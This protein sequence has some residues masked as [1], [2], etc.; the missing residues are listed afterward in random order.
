MLGSTRCYALELVR[1]L[2]VRPAA[3]AVARPIGAGSVCAT[4]A[5]IG[6]HH[7]PR[8]RDA[9]AASR[10]A[11]PT[12]NTVFLPRA[13]VCSANRRRENGLGRR[14]ALSCAPKCAD[15]AQA[16][17]KARNFAV[18]SA[19]DRKMNTELKNTLPASARTF[20]A[21]YAVAAR[22]TCGTIFRHGDSVSF[23]LVSAFFHI[24]GEK[25]QS[26]QPGN[27]CFR[28]YNRVHFSER[29]RLSPKK[30]RF[31]SPKSGDNS[32]KPFTNRAGW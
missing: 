29:S 14:R 26:D 6:V 2:L 12:P 19:L 10:H 30:E 28:A 15:R 17:C 13:L 3:A 25:I 8:C 23:R 1:T 31:K 24:S 21:L 20:Y 16:G 18:R 27:T 4:R 9:G 5:T 7:A 32:L 22:S 11:L